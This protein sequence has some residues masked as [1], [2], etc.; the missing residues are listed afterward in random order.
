M[1]GKF[2]V[3][4]GTDGVGKATQVRLLKEKLDSLGVKHQ[5]IDFPRYE[6]NAYGKII[7]SFLN[8]E[9][10]KYG[11]INPYLLTLAYAGDRSLAKDIINGWLK[12]GDLVIANRYLHSNVAYSIAKLPNEMKEEFIRWNYDLEYQ[13]NGI[14][15][16]ELVILLYAPPEVAQKNIEQRGKKDINEKDIE[17]QKKVAEAY[18]YLAKSQSHWVVIDCTKDGQMKS[19]EEIH[20]EIIK[21]FKE[22]AV[23]DV[24]LS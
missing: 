15:K 5:I 10:Q 8:G 23:L 1:N 13:T 6:D 20:R 4:E 19:K 18:L 9:I 24:K 16:E 3:I 22:K 2:I 12:N 21:V 7:R 17:Y 11:G 14:P